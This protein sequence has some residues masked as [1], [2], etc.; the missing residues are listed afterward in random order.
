M[1]Q[2]NA[3]LPARDRLQETRK[4]FEAHCNGAYLARHA[5]DPRYPFPSVLPQTHVAQFC[6]GPSAPYSAT[7]GYHIQSLGVVYSLI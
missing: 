6:D 1:D 4:K 5:A 2:L 3:R 7:S